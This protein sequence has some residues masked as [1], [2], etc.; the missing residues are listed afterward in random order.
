MLLLLLGQGELSE[1]QVC[2]EC[3]ALGTAQTT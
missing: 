1:V 2:R 3:K